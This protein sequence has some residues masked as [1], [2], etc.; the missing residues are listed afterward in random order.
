MTKRRQIFLDM[1]FTG[2][3]QATTPVSIGMVCGDSTFYG[4][5]FDYDQDRVGT[6]L[7]ANVFAKLELPEQFIVPGLTWVSGTRQEIA[8]ILKAWLVALGAVEVWAD[9]HA[10]DWVLFCE[11]F[12]GAQGIPDNVWYIPYDLAT[13]F[14]L[15]GED[16]DVN[17]YDFVG[18]DRDLQHNALADAMIESQCFNKLALGRDWPWTS[19]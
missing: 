9:V 7:N 10:Y 6:W 14:K 15:A 4:V 3:H 12:G 13:M 5:F 1:E 16:P 18:R 17:R 2:L 19:S 8:T 11:L